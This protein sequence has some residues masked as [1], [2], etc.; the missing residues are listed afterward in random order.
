[1]LFEMKGRVLPNLEDNLAH[2]A[3]RTLRRKTVELRLNTALA[4]AT[5]E[6]IVT[7]DGDEIPTSTLI[8]VA[9]VQANPIV[10]ALDVEKGRAG[11]LVV[12]ACLRVP[13]VPG[14][15]AL[16]DS[17][18][19]TDPET[20]KILP[21]DAKVAIQQASAV[22]DNVIRELSSEEPQPFDYR[23][24][25]DMISLGTN[26]AVAEVLG[27]KLTGYVAW[28]LWRT[29][30]LGRLQ[31]I[32]SKSRVATDWLLDTFLERYTAQLELE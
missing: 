15:Y 14:M 24:F 31:G 18:A 26:A 22:A 17:A 30:Y 3:A 10:G 20:D 11:S 5:G 29:Y 25:G 16:G 8:W 19:Y 13:S 27:F 2:V 7:K 4:S 9:G 1:V 23:F 21:A 32:E 12:D 28:L 6:K